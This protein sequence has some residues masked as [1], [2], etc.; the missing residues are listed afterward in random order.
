MNSF[1]YSLGSSCFVVLIL[2]VLKIH[3]VLI[4]I[5][6]ILMAPIFS[7]LSLRLLDLDIITRE[8]HV[9]QTPVI[10]IIWPLCSSFYTHV[11]ER[12]NKLVDQ[13]MFQTNLSCKFSNSIHQVFSLTVNFIL[14][15]LHFIGFHYYLSAK[16]ITFFLLLFK[17]ILLTCVSLLKIDLFL[18]FSL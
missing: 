18:V 4:E 5:L 9:W 12:G 15:I 17:L 14:Q 7:F 10:D 6:S 8:F 16:L 3:Y 2:T 13:E 1:I 11:L